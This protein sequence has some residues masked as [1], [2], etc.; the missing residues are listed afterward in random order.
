MFSTRSLKGLGIQRDSIGLY[1]DIIK[2]S[3]SV[4]EDFYRTSSGNSIGTCM[5]ILWEFKGM[6]KDLDMDPTW[7]SIWNL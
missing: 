7:T 1:L 2:N 4:L 5:I 3:I 6:L